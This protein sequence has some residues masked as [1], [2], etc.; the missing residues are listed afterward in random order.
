MRIVDASAA[1]LNAVLS[2]ERA[3]FAREDEAALVSDLL[4]DPSAQPSLSLPA[5]LQNKPVGPK[6]GARPGRSAVV[7][8]QS[9]KP[10]QARPDTA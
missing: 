5:F 7:N 6:A 8:P 4:Q 3:A 2:V 10:C 1:D 9:R